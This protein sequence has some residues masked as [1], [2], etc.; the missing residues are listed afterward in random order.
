MIISLSPINE[1][2]SLQLYKE[3]FFSFSL[4]FGGYCSGLMLLRKEASGKIIG[5]IWHMVFTAGRKEEGLQ[6]KCGRLTVDQA[7][8]N[9]S[10][11][12]EF[13]E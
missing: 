1:R 5:S 2:G 8:L 11:R 4:F 3:A 6:V 7:L 13:G 12:Y 9:T 10:C